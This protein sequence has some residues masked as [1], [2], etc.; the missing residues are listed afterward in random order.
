MAKYLGIYNTDENWSSHIRDTGYF[1]IWKYHMASVDQL[2]SGEKKADVTVL[3]RPCYLLTVNCGMQPRKSDLTLQ[4]GIKVRGEGK[5]L[6]FI[7]NNQHDARPVAQQ[8]H[9]ST[10]AKVKHGL[11]LNYRGNL[12]LCLPLGSHPVLLLLRSLTTCSKTGS[13]WLSY[14]QAY[15]EQVRISGHWV[16]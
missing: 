5:L 11:Q 4:N 7:S 9:H 14:L 3:T 10:S 13:V 15:P 6:D 1:S 8:M 12:Y 16:D 2:N